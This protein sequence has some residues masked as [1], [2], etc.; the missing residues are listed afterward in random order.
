M[1]M[2]KFLSL[3]LL[4]SLLSLNL[5]GQDLQIFNLSQQEFSGDE[6]ILY[7]SLSD[8]YAISSIPDSAAI[9]LHLLGKE[10]D[11]V[12]PVIHLD[13]NFRALFL[14]CTGLR[15]K[16][17]LYLFDA[18]HAKTKIIPIH[19]LKSVAVLSVYY[20]GYYGS[21]EAYDYQIGFEIDPAFL[22]EDGS[23]FILIALGQE[24]PFAEKPL[25]PIIREAISLSSDPI[26]Q[27]YLSSDSLAEITFI[28]THR[29]KKQ[30]LSYYLAD[31]ENHPL[32][33]RKLCIYDSQSEDW[34]FDHNFLEGESASHTPIITTPNTDPR[35]V[36]QWTGNFFK[37]EP[38]M[39]FGMQYQSFSCPSFFSIEKQSQETIM[40][41]DN[42]H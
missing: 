25:S 2:K 12:Y 42:R 26:L 22:A 36:Y 30:N 8:I 33:A 19:K 14:A 5:S 34:I 37:N 9:P 24:N 21:V 7:T 27:A 23:N 17:N 32:N 13:S 11:S 38:A 41:C 35:F 20:S 16:D 3:F 6:S 15:E 1:A 29:F 18:I 28:N 39:I 31:I 10:P 40:N 4:S